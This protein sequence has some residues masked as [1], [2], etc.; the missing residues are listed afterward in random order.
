MAADQDTQYTAVAA[1]SDVGGARDDA[2]KPMRADARRNRQRLVDAA[3]EV[4]T[5]QGASASMEAIAKRAGVG[6]GT[7]YRHFPN[8][9]DIVEA[10][11]QD[12][13][14]ELEDAAYRAVAEL[15]PWLA[16]E[17]FFEAFMSYARRKSAMMSELHQAF[18]KH[19]EFKS[20]MR[21]RIDGSFAL[22]MDRAKAAGVLRTDIE[23]SDVTQL[24]GPICTNAGISP[25]QSRRLVG[26]ILDGLRASAVPEPTVAPLAPTSA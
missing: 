14:D 15:E 26:M 10:V 18:E 13:V 24:V 19:P 17:A 22:V 5:E 1:G 2:E 8:R 9:F 4:F 7:L 12:D 20:K 25:A 11:Y 6:V 23:G 3:R 16:V 21:E